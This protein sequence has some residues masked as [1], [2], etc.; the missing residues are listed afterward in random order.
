MQG[1]WGHT[2]E[3]ENINCASGAWVHT[4]ASEY[5]ERFSANVTQNF[6]VRFLINE[7]T[8]VDQAT[9]VEDGNHFT[10][11]TTQTQWPQI[12]V[13]NWGNNDEQ[14]VWGEAGTY[15]YVFDTRITGAVGS[16]GHG[17]GSFTAVDG[18]DGVQGVWDTIAV[19]TTLSDR[20]LIPTGNP[21]FNYSL[22][23]ADKATNTKIAFD[24]MRLYYKPLTATVD[25]VANG[26]VVKTVT[27]VST[28]T[29]VT[30]AKLV[31]DVKLKGYKITGASF[32]GNT[33]TEE[34]TIIVPCDCSVELVLEVQDI[35]PA[36]PETASDETSVRTGDVSGIRF[37]AKLSKSE[38]ER[39]TAYGWI[40]TRESLLT[41]AGITSANF[42]KDSNVKKS[43]GYNYGSGTEV[44]KIFASDDT[45]ISFTAVLYFAN[46][47]ADNLPSV[48]K[49]ADKLVA[50][51]FAVV[52]GEYLYGD[53]TTPASIFDIAYN[54]YVNNSDDMGDWN[55]DV[56]AEL[57]DYCTNVILKCD[58]D[59]DGVP[60]L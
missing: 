42:T 35:D 54:F 44:A 22:D 30:V 28:E 40:V 26:E 57:A 16:I 6:R 36:T 21:I 4:I 23:A 34:D 3:I 48:E 20:G 17:T 38:L 5:D 10:E 58:D 52:D 1:W 12:T 31:E 33:Y 19:Q 50:R 24:N 14:K 7:G 41:D 56:S 27:N 37:M 60:N 13:V 49:L 51:P 32:G 9:K 8:H 11:G 29:G 25:V 18:F 46:V 53:P 43:M 45:S 47:D 15:T 39:A 2:Q 55:G 59:L